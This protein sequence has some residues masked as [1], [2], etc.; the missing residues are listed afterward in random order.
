M[1]IVHAPMEIGGQI[2]LFCKTL[3]EEG[4]QAVGFQFYRTFHGFTDHIVPTDQYEL[5][6]LFG[7][8]MDDFDLFHFHF[9]MS[10]VPGYGDLDLLAK[11]GKPMVMHH[12][13][14]DV[15]RSS[16]ASLRN[17]YVVT[18]RSPKEEQIHERLS[19]VGAVIPVGIVQDY[20]VYDYVKP[21]YNEVH[22]LPLAVD[23]DRLRPAYPKEEEQC[24][25][26]V[27]APTDPAF[28]GTAIVERI[29]GELQRECPLRYR[30]IERMRHAEAVALYREA[31]IVIDQLL[32]GS[33]GLLSVEAMALGKPAVAFV[34]DDLLGT[35]PGGSPPIC[36]ANPDTLYD[37]LKTLLRSGSLRRQKGIEG[38]AYAEAHHDRRAVTRQ[39]LRLY[40]RVAGMAR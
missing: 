19:R 10:I 16:I 26:V 24:P 28:K 31:D 22:V 15:R 34:R 32:C 6:S 9:T 1:K 38:R 39:L 8:L 11:A 37:V 7:E 18:G 29:V 13:G 5:M 2:G 35:F 27:H 23:L 30:R 12:W 33:Y 25:L 4:H 36:S 17:P 21:Y 20:E 14:N 40:S 3:N